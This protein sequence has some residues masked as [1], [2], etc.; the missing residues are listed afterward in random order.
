MIKQFAA[1]MAATAVISAAAPV[2]AAPAQI[3][4]E[5]SHS[6]ML[7][8]TNSKIIRI[9]IANPNIADVAVFDKENV[10]I[11][12]KLAGST[13]LMVWTADGMRQDFTVVV[14]GTDEATAQAIRAAMH[15][16]DV[17]VE[18]VGLGDKRKI[19]LSG[20]VE[21]Q[22]EMELAE[23][24]SAL[25]VEGAWTDGTDSGTEFQATMSGSSGMSG[26][27]I[28]YTKRVHPNIINNIQIRN[29]IQ[30]NLA[31]MVLDVR[32]NDAEK[33]GI[34]YGNA[35]SMG[36]AATTTEYAYTKEYDE[37]GNFTGY[38]KTE[39]PGSKFY[40]TPDTITFGEP[41]LFAGGGNWHALTGRLMSNVDA[42]LQLSVTEGKTKVLSRPN[43]TTLSNKE[44][45]ILIGG[46]IPIPQTD[47]NNNPTV[48]WREYGI[49]MH[50]KP[51]VDTKGKISA[52]LDSEISSLDWANAVD[53]FPALITRKVSTAVDMMDGQTMVI[54]G[55]L[56]DMDNKTLTKIP[57]LGDIPILGEFFK[58]RS[59]SK[60][61]HELVIL[62]KPTIIRMGD[63]SKVKVGEKMGKFIEETKNDWNKRKTIDVNNIPDPNGDSK[64]KK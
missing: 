27:N 35:G 42:I 34:K 61:K 31:I 3:M 23:N 11:I 22:N 52:F 59:N 2:Y 47:K 58:Y 36:L 45:S 6:Q 55:L 24:V 26:S 15:L 19:L 43:I 62:I 30:V 60:D 1:M 64:S 7:R 12:G 53:K 33:Y 37:K 46:E 5:V 48:Q 51:V 14:K 63:A 10:S 57:I 44:A 50:I 29:P 54:G 21:D 38:K 32:G 56:N 8:V 40:A 13:T 49:R 18:L 4:L 39:A 28:N 16:P 9:A 41:G 20:F 25:Y 17:E